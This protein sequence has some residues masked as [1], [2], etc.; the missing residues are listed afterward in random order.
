[1]ISSQNRSE[2]I[3]AEYKVMRQRQLI[4]TFPMIPVMIV[5][6]FF[7]DKIPKGSFVAT[8]FMTGLLGYA[9]F[10]LIFSLFNWRCPSCKGYLGK[11]INPKHC[12]KCGIELR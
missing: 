9:V 8:I 12:Q 2:I 11:T 6:L 4:A 7:E 3:K 5:A 1:M 10:C